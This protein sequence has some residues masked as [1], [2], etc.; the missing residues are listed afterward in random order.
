MNNISVD[1]GINSPRTDG[2]IRV[3]K[4]STAGTVMD[5]TIQGTDWQDPS[6]TRASYQN[7]ISTD[8]ATGM[9]R[10]MPAADFVTPSMLENRNWWMATP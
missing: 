10:G 4:D 7:D 3:D 9:L 6:K 5:T 8:A 1:N 2:Q